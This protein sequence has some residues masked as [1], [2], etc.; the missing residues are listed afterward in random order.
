MAVQMTRSISEPLRSVGGNRYSGRRLL[1]VP[2]AIVALLLAGCD[3]G[4]S[5]NED[6]LNAEGVIVDVRG[7]ITEVESFELVLPGGERLTIEPPGGVLERSGFSPAHLREHMALAERIT[8][9]YRE[10]DGRNV[11]IAVGDAGG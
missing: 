11:L 1:L 6:G 4:S 9:T 2:L 10:E 8:L 7:T 5:E 3:A